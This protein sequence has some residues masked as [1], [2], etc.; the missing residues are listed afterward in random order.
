[1]RIKVTV[2]YDGTNYCGWQVQKN[3]R[4]IQELLQRALETVLRHPIALTGAGRTDAGVHALGQTAHFDADFEDLD[5]LHYSANALL[6]PDIR[7]LSLEPVSDQF[8][9]RYSAIGKEYHYHLQL[10]EAADPTLRLYRTPI[11]GLFDRKALSAA[12]ALFL[13]THDFSAFANRSGKELTDSVRTITRLD[14]VDE[15]GGIRL[16]FEGNGFL[17]KMVRNITG[18]LL[19]VAAHKRSLES[20]Q[21]LLKGRE[22]VFAGAAVLPQGLFLIKVKY[23]PAFQPKFPQTT[24]SGERPLK[25]AQEEDGAK[26]KSAQPAPVSEEALSIL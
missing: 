23:D 18:T 26:G 14:I 6:P 19:E 2:S 22:R 24:Q 16:E 5:R 21:E 15:P 1:M 8:H 25:K 9:A 20:I 11:F 10:D 13:G 7:I 12:A 4:S 17:Y 3:G